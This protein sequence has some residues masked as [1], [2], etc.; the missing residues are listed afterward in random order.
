M[1]LLT[2]AFVFTGC[3]EG[4]HIKTVAV[5]DRAPGKDYGA[6]EIELFMDDY[7]VDVINERDVELNVEPDFLSIQLLKL[8]ASQPSDRL[9]GA[10]ALGE[11]LGVDAVVYSTISPF[12]E[13]S[14]DKA[15]CLAGDLIALYLVDPPKVLV[16]ASDY[17]KFLYR[18]E[19]MDWE[20]LVG[21]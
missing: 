20:K 7:G 13:K 3:R 8:C 1:A 4:Y 5:L 10:V 19:I 17:D 6:E 12:W 11:Q 18:L 2:V 21:E 16:E 9:E 15:P 14:R